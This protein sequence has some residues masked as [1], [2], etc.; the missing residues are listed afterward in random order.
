MGCRRLGW[1]DGLCGCGAMTETPPELWNPATWEFEGTIKVATASRC[2]YLRI[3][4]RTAVSS[5]CK[6]WIWC[7][8]AEIA[9]MHP[10]TGSLSLTFA[11]YIMP[12]QI[13][14]FL[15]LPGLVKIVLHY[16]DIADNK[17]FW[18]NQR[19]HIIIILNRMNLV[20]IILDIDQ[21]CDDHENKREIN[22]KKNNKI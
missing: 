10:Y 18:L 12:R 14:G 5:A 4:D 2:L 11:S 1:S 3:S 6:A 17:Y 20:D 15:V 21:W 16:K 7:C 13:S 22:L 8:R 9:P 19:F